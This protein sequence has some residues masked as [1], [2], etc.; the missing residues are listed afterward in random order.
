[1]KIAMMTNNYKPF[2]A[3]V[4]ISIERLSQG[5]RE[6]GHEVTVF[7]PTYKQQMV[8]KDVVRYR[9]F[10]EGPAGGIAIP[11][12]WDAQ[13]EKVFEKEQFD[14]IHVHHPMLIGKTA[15]SLSKKY[16]IPLVFTYHTRYEQY[17]HYLKPM[18]YLKKAVP[19]YLKKFL[20]HCDHVFAPTQGMEDYLIQECGQL[21]DKVSVLPTG[22]Q[23]DS[24]H[25]DENQ[26]QSIRERYCHE[27][28]HLF[29]CVSRLAE[30][31]NI[32]FL[33]RSLAEYKRQVAAPFK[34]L[35][36]GDGPNREEYEKE[37]K[38]LHLDAEVVFTGKVA[39]EELKNYYGAADLFLFASK[40]E[41]QGIV[42][43]EAMAAGLPVIA[44]KASGVEDLVYNGLNGFL[45]PEETE[46]F[47]RCMMDILTYKEKRM[48]LQA[49]A[50]RYAENFK[51]EKIAALAVA[52]YEQVLA[53]YQ[54]KYYMPSGYT[55]C[56]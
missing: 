47:A 22:L 26:K 50:A 54:G 2:L 40:T 39:N 35:F 1:M 49:G 27:G 19:L 3:G 28:E 44:V 24:Y 18:Q 34:M 33:L 13:I 46:L 9:T 15:V 5:L 41:T 4:P 7:A 32:G 36:V 8:E 25:P 17:L 52:C 38:R 16:G 48:F 53:P 12:V 56:Y 23:E 37:V 20:V 31:K 55:P 29:L 14:L 30:E 6:L 45:V 11:N 10:T 43:L 42:I 21:G 51:E